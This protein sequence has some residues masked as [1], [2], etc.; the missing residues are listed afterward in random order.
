[1]TP[2]RPRPRRPL[3]LV[4]THSRSHSRTDSAIWRPLPRRPGPRGRRAPGSSSGRIPSEAVDDVTPYL[5]AK[6]FYNAPLNPLSALLKATYGTLAGT[7]ST[8]TL[9]D[10]IIREAFDVA[11]RMGVALPWTICDEYLH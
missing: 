5:W 6:V 2:A 8:K 10:R 7:P 9:M 4:P 1:M 11:R 3:F